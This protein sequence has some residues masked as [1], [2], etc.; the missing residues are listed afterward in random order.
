MSLFIAS[1]GFGLVTASILAIAAV[2]FTL[3]I[4]IAN[5]FNLTYG[6]TMIACAFFA[7]GF[8]QAGLNIWLCMPLAGLFGMVFS[9]ALN[10]F[11]FR[12]FVRRG[13]S[14]FGMV[15]VTMA[16]SFL[17]GN[18]MLAIWGAHY[19][20]YQLSQGRT[21][22][23]G[24][25]VLT[26]SQLAII[27]LSVIL[28]LGLHLLLRG[29]KLGQAMRATASNPTLARASGIRTSTMIDVV[30]AL[31]GFL[32]G[33]AGVALVMNTSSFN[34]SSGAAF[35]IIVV[36]AAVLGGVGRPYGAML[37]ALIVGLATEITPVVLSP[38]YKN[39]IAFLILIVII[40]MRPQ[41]LL[42]TAQ[43]FSAGQLQEASA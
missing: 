2:G 23:L 5:L 20:T 13:T 25:I 33:V 15:I 28:M 8:N 19:F 11:L 36:A 32:S 35:M 31:S 42:A 17:I 43:A 26:E 30:W 37:G 38:A 9:V 41:G 34:F 21:L 6:V 29:T 4:G 1:I 18:V 14:L 10:R 12:P 3:Q 39:V 7:Y 22:R 40:M 27:G 24:S 16:A